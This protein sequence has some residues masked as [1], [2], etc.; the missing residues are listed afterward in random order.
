M[1]RQ[2]CLALPG[3]LCGGMPFALMLIV[4]SNNEEPGMTTTDGM[5]NV[6]S[7][8]RVGVMRACAWGGLLYAMC[9]LTLA[10]TPADCPEAEPCVAEG[11]DA[12]SRPYSAPLLTPP[13]QRQER[14]RWR[15]AL[16]AQPL[17]TVAQARYGRGEA[18][19]IISRLEDDPTQATQVRWR[20]GRAS[21]RHRGE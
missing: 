7:R 6:G 5:R 11:R 9:G 15:Q 1:S 13:E 19:Q 21:G 17:W 14:R 8:V 18:P 2:P 12:V 20:P 10:G 3:A 4:R 16:R